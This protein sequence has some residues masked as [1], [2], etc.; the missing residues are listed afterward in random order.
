MSVAAA[1]RATPSRVR[2]AVAP[3]SVARGVS[4]AN[5]D[6]TRA[7]SAA[8]AAAAGRGATART[9]RT[10][11]ASSASASAVPARAAS[12]AASSA[13]TAGSRGSRRRMAGL[14][15]ALDGA[16]HAGP[17]VRRRDPEHPGDLGVVEPGEELERD[18]LA[19]A[20]LEACEGGAYGRPADGVAAG[21]VGHRLGR[22][23]LGGERRD[24]PPPAELV[25][26]RVAGDAEQP[27]APAAA[28]RVVAAPA[29]V[30]ALERR[31]RRR[32]RPRRG[33]A[34][35]SRRTRRGRRPSRG[36]ARRTTPLRPGRRGRGRAGRWWRSHRHYGRAGDPSRRRWRIGR[37][38]RHEGRVDALSVLEVR[39]AHDALADVAAALR[40][41]QRR[42]VLDVDDEPD[43]RRARLGERPVGERA[44]DR[45]A[46][47]A[48][49]QPRGPRCSRA[50]A[51][52]RRGR[53]RTR[54]RRR[55]TARRRRPL[56][57][58]RACRSPARPRRGAATRARSRAASDQGRA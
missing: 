54:A 52:P 56:R 5:P 19:V 27:L 40:D 39:G 35:A 38:A 58:P 46:R 1:E 48:A 15:E 28:A 49:A 53:C 50:R 16:V 31:R 20:R 44:E 17:G 36:T 18:E 25:E 8:R 7:S 32:P 23:G 3:P 47:P 43:P 45:R 6:A 24:A 9:S 57:T 34:R 33:R 37:D 13:S 21:V 26:R 22:P 42:R 30:G 29:A 14:P 12:S 55:G 51:R 2:R 41:A 4:G 11:A 10:S